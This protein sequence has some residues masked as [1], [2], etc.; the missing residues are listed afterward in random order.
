[1]DKNPAAAHRVHV[2]ICFFLIFM[3]NP[4]IRIYQSRGFHGI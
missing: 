3:V 4:G 2:P 1:M